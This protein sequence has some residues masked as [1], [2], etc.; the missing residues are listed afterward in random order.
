MDHSPGR[1]FAANELKTMM[2]H[3]VL[4]YDM[5]L[6]DAAAGRPK[7]LE[8]EGSVLPNQTASIMLRKRSS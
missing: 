2:V 1:Y 7:N 6:E 4:N 3:L 5:K 8:F